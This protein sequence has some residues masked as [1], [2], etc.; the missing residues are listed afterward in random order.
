[1]SKIK[2]GDITASPGVAIGDGARSS[3]RITKEFDAA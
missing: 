1:M 2:V 3:V